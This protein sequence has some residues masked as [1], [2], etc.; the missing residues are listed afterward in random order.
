MVA[1]PFPLL[2]TCQGRVLV[3]RTVMPVLTPFRE[4]SKQISE[5]R[6]H[7]TAWAH[8]ITCRGHLN[9]VGAVG[10]L[11]ILPH[12]IPHGVQRT[13]AE[14]CNPPNG[15]KSEAR[16]PKK[17]DVSIVLQEIQDQEACVIPDDH[18][19]PEPKG[20]RGVTDQG[21]YLRLPLRKA[22]RNS[23]G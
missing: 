11:L 6:G 16:A 8:F 10:S 3:E 7:R 22:L 21:T 14:C 23:I 19:A 15:L 13:S 17:A 4:I 2:L 9:R 5:V 20:G 18:L 12:R 1:S